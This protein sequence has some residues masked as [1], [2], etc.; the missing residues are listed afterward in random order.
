MATLD[1]SRTH[2]ARQE[3]PVSMAKAKYNLMPL[4]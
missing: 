3:R 4:R 2:A 1:H